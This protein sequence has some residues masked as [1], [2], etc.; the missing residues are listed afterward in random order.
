VV[1]QWIYFDVTGVCDDPNPEQEFLIIGS[2]SQMISR[3]FN[4]LTV[5]DGE[6]LR[7]SP[8]VDPEKLGVLI[9]N[10]AEPEPKGR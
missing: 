3:Q 4:S 1:F 8:Q 10:P 7:L 2:L 6:I 5:G 9:P